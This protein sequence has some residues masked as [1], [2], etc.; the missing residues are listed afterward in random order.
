[1]VLTSSSALVVGWALPASYC[2]T[3]HPQAEFQLPPTTPGHSP[4]SASGSYPCSFQSA[5]SAESLR[6]CEIF[7]C[8]LWDRSPF[9]SPFSPLKICFTGFKVRHS[10]DLTF[11]LWDPMWS[12]GLSLLG[13][14]SAIIVILLLI[15]R[16]PGDVGLDCTMSSPL[17]SH[18]PVVLP[19]YL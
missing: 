18:L 9:P 17:L 2:Q 5:A 6:V 13:R 8:P 3:L 16:L 7:V 10:G 11:M 19:L 4:I 12:L 15:D 14:S 1:M